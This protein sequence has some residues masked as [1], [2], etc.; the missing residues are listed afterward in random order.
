MS[1]GGSS[2]CTCLLAALAVS[3]AWLQLV[4]AEEQPPTE[5][6]EQEKWNKIRDT[7]VEIIY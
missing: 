7:K 5:E 6:T 4:Q 2:F 1:R 3:T